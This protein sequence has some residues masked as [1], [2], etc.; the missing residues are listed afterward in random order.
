MGNSERPN[1]TVTEIESLLSLT[2]PSVFPNRKE[3]RRLVHDPETPQ[4]YIEAIADQC[5]CISS[6]HVPGLHERH[7]ISQETTSRATR[8]ICIYVDNLTLRAFYGVH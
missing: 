8:V 5:P 6:G 1:C 3:L 7:S 4:T 2:I